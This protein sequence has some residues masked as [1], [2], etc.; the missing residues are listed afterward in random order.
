MAR[1]VLLLGLVVLV[2]VWALGRRRDPTGP[3]QG[4]QRPTEGVS[5]PGTMVCCARCGLHLPQT[6]ALQDREGRWYC[7]EPH[8]AQG[9]AE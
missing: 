4:S 9:A 6:E 8:R 7:G 1:I 3:G 2:L 5:R